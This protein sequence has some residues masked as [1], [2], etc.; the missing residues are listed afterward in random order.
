MGMDLKP[1]NPTKDAP[2]YPDDGESG[3]GEVIWGRYNWSG[4]T[5]I[6]DKL[7]SWGVD[8]TDFSGSN[9][10][11]VIPAEKCIEV[12]NAIESHLNDLDEED[13]EW[14]RPHI[15]KWRTC[16]GYEQW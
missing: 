2:R 12:A 5:Y 1:I 8:L 9:D 10:G 6:T 11:G 16:G 13:R 3:S 14:L 7:E 4:W 15:V